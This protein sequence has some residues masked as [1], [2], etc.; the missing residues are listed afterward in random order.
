MNQKETII[1]ESPVDWISIRQSGVIAG[2][3][4]AIKAVGY[5]DYAVTHLSYDKVRELIKAL[6]SKI[7]EK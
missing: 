4:L 2:G 3:G 6:E 7:T 1:A 5:P